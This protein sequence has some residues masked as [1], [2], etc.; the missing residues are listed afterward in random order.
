MSDSKP[1][2]IEEKAFLMLMHLSQLAGFIIPG[3]GLALPIV[4]WATNKDSS[5][6][7]D[8]QGK[9][10]LNWIISLFIYVT[11]SVILFVVFIGVITLTVVLI[12]NLIFII[13]GAIKAN[14]GET[15][16]YP[17]SIKFFKV[18]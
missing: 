15:W 3:A 2:G 12:I 18:S 1:W 6:T 7:I 9:I 8:N 11:V 14:N 13:I 16:V 10:I 4:M 17:L 5:K